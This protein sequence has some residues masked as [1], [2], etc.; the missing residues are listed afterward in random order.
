KAE[1]ERQIKLHLPVQ[2]VDDIL[3]GKYFSISELELK[4][5]QSQE[6][7]TNLEQEI[8]HL[9]QKVADQQAILDQQ[10]QSTKVVTLKHD[11]YFM[12]EKFQEKAQE[13]LIHQI[14]LKQIEKTKSIFQTSY[15]P[16]VLAKAANFIAKMTNNRY[17]KL[18]FDQEER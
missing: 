3:A 2:M 12:K 10:A 8:N 9:Y 7:M 4:L 14:A 5:E 15:L 11:Y 18:E 17:T 16:D 6:I 13:W 1:L